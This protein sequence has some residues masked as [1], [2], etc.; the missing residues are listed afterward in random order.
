[1]LNCREPE[2]GW[3]HAVRRVWLKQTKPEIKELWWLPKA[4]VTFMR[5][6]VKQCELLKVPV[7]KSSGGQASCL[8]NANGSEV[9]N[10][11]PGLFCGVKTEWRKSQSV[12]NRASYNSMAALEEASKSFSFTQKAVLRSHKF[13]RVKAF[14]YSFKKLEI[15]PPSR[16]SQN[17]IQFIN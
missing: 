17:K 16:K 7:E 15:H 14:K 12:R 5:Q 8:T 2:H 1:M 13:Q 6:E 9:N 3:H 11:L 4:H 10:E